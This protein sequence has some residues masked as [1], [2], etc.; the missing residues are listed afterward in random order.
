MD[1]YLFINF[2]IFF[3]ILFFYLH[4]YNNIKTSNYL[5]IYEFEQLSKEKLEEYCNLKQPI[6]LNSENFLNIDIDYLQSN[7]NGFDIKVVNKESSDILLPIKLGIAIDLFNKDISSNYISENNFDFLNET[8]VEK[9]YSKNDL[10]LRPYNNSYIQY[11]LIMG[12]INSYTNFKYS[13]SCRNYFNV[14]SGS[15]E[16]TM[17]PPKNAKYLFVNKNYEDLNFYSSI[18]I[19]NVKDIYKNDFN[20]IKLLRIV[21]AK[22]QLLF[23]PPYWFYSIKILE[24]NTLVA[25]YQYRTFMNQVAIF[26][27]LC[28]QFLQKNNIKTNITKI[29]KT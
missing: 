1:N 25:Y 28:I 19:N 6:L 14:L 22:N 7:Y 26:P 20:K 27:E 24:K 16:I 18:D 21:L 23:I 5:E 4:V 12:S 9:E 17:T 13:L 8:S 15:I 2:L 29:I 10:M 11:D 3:I